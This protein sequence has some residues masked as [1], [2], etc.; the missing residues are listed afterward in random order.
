MMYAETSLLREEQVTTDMSWFALTVRS[1]HEFVARD[2]LM[3]KGIET[4]LPSLRKVQQW[5]DRKKQVEF[6]VFPGYCF[7][8]IEPRAEQF[9]N[10]IKTRG[11]VTLVSLVPGHPTPVPG[12]EIEALRTVTFSGQP[13]DVYPGYKLGMR[14]RVRRGPLQGAEGVLGNRESSQMFFVN[15]EILGR[16][17]GLRIAAEDIE[18]I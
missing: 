7:V 15:I 8:N 18:L 9:L 11:T 17:V 6:P 4:F 2:E 10:V 3:K 16:S 5:R 13:F 12:E 1:R 14:V